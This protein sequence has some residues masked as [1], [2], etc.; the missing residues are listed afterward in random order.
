MNIIRQSAEVFQIREANG[1]D[2]I[3]VVMQDCGPGRGKLLLECHGA[4]WA[5]YWGAMPNVGLREFLT[6]ADAEY[7]AH[8]M[9]S[10]RH[11][12]GVSNVRRLVQ[13]VEALQAALKAA[14]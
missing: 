9:V 4:A 12:R 6:G 1:L 7:I 10:P 8:K 14:P 5:G 11:R 13:I 2:P 3:T